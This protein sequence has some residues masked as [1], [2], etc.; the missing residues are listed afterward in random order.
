MIYQ[1]IKSPNFSKKKRKKHKINFVVIHYTGMQSKIASIKRL[2]NPIHK[3]SCHY[4]IDRT[5]TVIQMI[6]DNQ[7][8]WHAGK[9][10]WK[11]IKNLNESSIGIELVNKGH[12][13]K[14]QNFT[15]NQINSLIK[16]CKILKKK[17]KIKNNCFLGHSDI[18]PLRKLDPGEKFPWLTLKKKGIGIWYP[19]LKNIKTIEKKNYRNS[20][21]NNIFKIGYRYFYKNSSSKND[22]LIVKAFQR[23]FLQNKVD[24]KIDQKTFKISHY[25]ANSN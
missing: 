22:K 24:G 19:E 10:K 14:Y 21:F 15:K 5:G 18:S 3:V 9:S 20:F 2:I 8:A 6:K 1:T 11:E 7:I 12:K 17:Y 25:L 23:K 13:F 16:L 4:L